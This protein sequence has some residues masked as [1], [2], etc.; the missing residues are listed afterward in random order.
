MAAAGA[1]CGTSGTGAAD[2]TAISGFAA[3]GV[4]TA[5]FAGA[6]ALAAGLTTRGGDFLGVAAT[7]ARGFATTFGAGFFLTA[8]FTGGALAARRVAALAA[9]FDA[10]AGLRVGF[11][12]AEAAFFFAAGAVWL[13]CGR[14]CACLRAALAVVL[15][16]EIADAADIFMSN[17][18][19]PSPA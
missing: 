3:T 5:G 19:F 2:A 15:R 13:A 6:G 16:S 1:G 12:A 17:L 10:T 18:V 14:A 7:D 11:A 9:D 8:V 4:F